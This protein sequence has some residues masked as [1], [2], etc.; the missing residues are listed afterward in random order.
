MNQLVK[1]S[2]NRLK[3]KIAEIISRLAEP[4]FWLPLMIWLVLRRAQ[5]PMR[6]QVI[7]YLILLVFVFIVP[8]GY[9]SYLVFVKKEVDMDFTVRSKRVGL[10]VKSMLSFTAAPIITLFIDRLVFVITTAVYLST[11]G[12]VLVTLKWKISFH[13]GLNTLIFYTV[14]Y[15][16]DWRYWWLFFLLIPISWAR[17]EMKKHN[18]AQLIAG[19]VLPSIIFMIIT[20]IL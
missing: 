3:H 2:T 20:S 5:L 9:F 16:Y 10:I 4:L 6:E 8:F 13:A 12:L 18:P 17:L 1:P 14:N 15:L 7:N 11:L 19:V